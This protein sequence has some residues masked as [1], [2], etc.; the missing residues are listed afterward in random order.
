MTQIDDK[1]IEAVAEAYF[2]A[3]INTVHTEPAPYYDTRLVYKEG[4]KAAIQALVDMGWRK[5]EWLPISSA[6]RDK[7]VLVWFNSK[8][9]RGR[10]C[11]KTNKWWHIREDGR[12]DSSY[13]GVLGW[14]PS[15]WR[16]MLTPPK[17]E[18]ERCTETGDMFQ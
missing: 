5:D 13:N 12:L 17:Q 14:P 4:A 8:F 7:E 9:V 2:D 1:T 16:S 10:F 18:T 15:Y 6:P 3:S 11:T